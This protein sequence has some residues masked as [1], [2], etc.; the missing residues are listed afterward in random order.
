MK[1]RISD[2]LPALLVF[3]VFLYFTN[4]VF[5]DQIN[6]STQ[7][8]KFAFSLFS[9]VKPLGVCTLGLLLITFSSGLF[10][11]KLKRRF[12]KTHTIFAWLTIIFALCHGILVAVLF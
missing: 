1:A 7:E 11:K 10:R 5:A 2:Y 6:G 3:F 4:T 9:F 12:M 8:D